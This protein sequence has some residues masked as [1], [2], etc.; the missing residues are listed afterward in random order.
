VFYL[1]ACLALTRWWMTRKAR[2][3]LVGLAAL[4]LVAMLA[5]GLVFLQS[6]D[7]QERLHPV[8][9]IAQDGVVLRNGN[10]VNY[11]ARY[12]G[13]PLNRG[14]EARLLFQRDNWLQIELAGGETG[15]VATQ[16]VLLGLP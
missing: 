3:L 7:R 12:E 10:G 2:L 16:D 8:V 15:W 6:Q 5:M 4:S 1:P 13:I 11:P 9:V 14:V